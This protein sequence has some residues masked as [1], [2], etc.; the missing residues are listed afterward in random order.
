MRSV[1]GFE[2]VNARCKIS[3]DHCQ[4]GCHLGTIALDRPPIG[5]DAP[6]MPAGARDTML[7]STV[8]GR[9]ARTASDARETLRRVG[10][11]RWSGKGA[12]LGRDGFA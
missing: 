7:P 8:R 10:P 11:F 6:R 12:V 3:D 1:T 5:G 2:Y 4:V 9:H